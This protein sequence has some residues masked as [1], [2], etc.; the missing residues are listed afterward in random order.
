MTQAV[1]SKTII[2]NAEVINRMILRRIEQLG[3]MA[4]M[5]KQRARMTRRIQNLYKLQDLY[6]SSGAHE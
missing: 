3:G 2:I 1:I 5:S 4:V 6:R